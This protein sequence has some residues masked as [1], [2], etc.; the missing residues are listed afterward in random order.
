VRPRIIR[1]MWDV[2]AESTS[3]IMKDMGVSLLTSDEHT[4][5]R[6]KTAALSQSSLKSVHPHVSELMT[7]NVCVCVFQSHTCYFNIT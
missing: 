6:S 2:D 7:S 1:M 5:D 4:A 3:A